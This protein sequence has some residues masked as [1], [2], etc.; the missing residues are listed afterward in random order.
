MKAAIIPSPDNVEIMDVPVPEVSEHDVLVRIYSSGI[1]GT[2]V[3]IFRG[4]YMG[5][6]PIIPGHEFGGVVEAVGSAVSRIRVGDRVAIEPNIACDNCHACLNNRQNFCENWNGVG[7][8]LPGGMAEL[9]AVPEKAV[10]DI[11]DLPF[12]VA[13]FVEPLA[14]V[15]HGVE[16]ARFRLGDRVLIVG[17][18]PIGILLT[19]TI[20][21][22][23]AFEITQVDKNQD[24]LALAQASGATH[25]LSSLDSVTEDAF[26][27][28]VD[29]TGVPSLMERTLG[30]A[31]YG[32]TVLLFGVPPQ[33]STVTFPAFPIFRKGLT[34]LSSF[35][36]VRNSVQ[37]VRLLQGG[38]LDVS[39]LVSH[40]L[41]L[42]DLR[43]GLNLMETGSD[44]ALKIQISP[45]G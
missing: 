17:A 22:Q 2:D 1:C 11:G 33:Q 34:I 30:Y 43:T 35:T 6:Y 20:L 25:V 31:R 37:A 45:N 19:K 7:V 4:D 15:L 32:G 27:V 39:S 9:V 23:G 16:R 41:P 8:T 10:F 18:G 29:A 40:T 14:C 21:L 38:A 5:S 3:H 42:Q 44:G 36:S 12:P 26:D 24:R 28:V 13:A